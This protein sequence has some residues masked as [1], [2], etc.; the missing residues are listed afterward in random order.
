ML[1]GYGKLYFFELKVIVQDEKPLEGVLLWD[2]GGVRPRSYHYLP[3]RQHLDEK[4]LFVFLESAS[5]HVDE[6]AVSFL[7]FRL[8]CQFLNGVAEVDSVP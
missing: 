8:F 2:C 6:H 4:I 5:E 3:V 1:D 7:I